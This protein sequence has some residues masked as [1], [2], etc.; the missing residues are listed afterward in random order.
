MKNP[1]ILCTSS[2]TNLLSSL[3]IPVL[4][5]N[6]LNLSRVISYHNLSIYDLR[7]T[8]Q[9]TTRIVLPALLHALL[10]TS[11]YMDSSCTASYS[12]HRTQY[13]LS[14]MELSAQYRI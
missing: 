14:P 3:S 6:A 11:Y 10:H 12:Q 1:F 2:S 5:E 8:Y 13:A 4:F 7:C 9:S